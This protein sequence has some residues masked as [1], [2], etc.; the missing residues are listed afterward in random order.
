MAENGGE[1]C[2]KATPCKNCAV[3]K[4]ALGGR[5]GSGFLHLQ[6]HP[7][8]AADVEQLAGEPAG[9]F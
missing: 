5:E 1:V 9:L 2:Q 3:D 7:M 8:A 6:G 4:Y